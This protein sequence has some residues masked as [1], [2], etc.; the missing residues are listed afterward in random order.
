[1]SLSSIPSAP[2]ISLAIVAILSSIPAV[3]TR[4]SRHIERRT[5]TAT[6]I[7]VVQETKTVALG[8]GLRGLNNSTSELDSACASFGPVVTHDGIGSAGCDGKLLHNVKFSIS[9]GREPI[10]GHND[11][12]AELSRVADVL[13]QILTASTHEAE[14]LLGVLRWYRH[15]CLDGSTAPV[16]FQ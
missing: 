7:A 14:V 15:T 1:M 9:I 6:T 11:G 8:C 10:N 16:H 4:Q 13:R 3:H 12:D 5:A 2:Y